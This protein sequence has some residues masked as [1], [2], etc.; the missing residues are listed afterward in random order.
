MG[1]DQSTAGYD[2]HRLSSLGLYLCSVVMIYAVGQIWLY[3]KFIS[4]LRHLPLIRVSNQG[5]GDEL[6]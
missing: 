2:D 1:H 3:P 5:T 4:P 6:V